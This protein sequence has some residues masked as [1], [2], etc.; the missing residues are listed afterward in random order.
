MLSTNNS[1]AKDIWDF[2]LLLGAIRV[3]FS[4]QNI[5]SQDISQNI[6]SQ[7][8]SQNIRSQD[9][10]QNI[11]TQDILYLLTSI[12]KSRWHMSSTS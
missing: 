5:R 6:R 8:I 3:Y 2:A 7:D 4:P 9:I 1:G 11:T 10:S 12:L